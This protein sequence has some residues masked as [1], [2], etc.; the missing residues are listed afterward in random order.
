MGQKYGEKNVSC[1]HTTYPACCVAN[2]CSPWPRM[3][4]NN[5]VITSIIKQYL[6]IQHLFYF[7][8]F[9]FLFFLRDLRVHGCAKWRFTKY[10][11]LLKIREQQCFVQ[12]KKKIFLFLNLISSSFF[13]RF[14]R[15]IEL[16]VL[17]KT[18]PNLFE[19]HT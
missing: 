1:P 8:G 15:F 5:K 19:I 6:V 2:A 16:C 17:A 7:L 4:N 3:I 9:L 12:R 11:W 14:E 18:L 13:V 10:L